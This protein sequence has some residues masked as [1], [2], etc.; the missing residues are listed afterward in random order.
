MRTRPSLNLLVAIAT[1]GCGSDN[2]K[3]SVST[4]KDNVCSQVAAVACYDLY[5]CCSEGQIEQFL[6]V[7]D[8]RTEDQCRDDVQKLC[9]QQIGIVSSSIAA[10]RAKFDPAV[11]NA[12]LKAFLPKGSECATVGD[13]LPWTMACMMS[14]WQGTVADGGMCFFAFE[15]ASTD[16]YCAANQTCVALPV[17]GQPC[18]PQGCASTAF[19]QNGTC[20]AR[21]AQGGMCNQTRDCQASLYCDQGTN[22]CQPLLPGGATC[23]GNASCVSG[24]CNP[25]LCNGTNNPCFDNTQCGGMC[26]AG[27]NVGNFCQR[28]SQCGGG[29]CSVTTTMQ[30][31]AGGGCPPAETCVF[32]YPCSVG[33]C[34]GDV[35]CSA[36]EVAIDYCTAPSSIPT[37]PPN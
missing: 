14:A 19:C 32:P 15:C 33:T 27:P 9:E 3:P 11:M 7:G 2:S 6:H 35:V 21:V 18:A 12:C 22:M 8:P 37:P 10:G 5:Q 25:G 29:H 24:Q 13:A 26:S 17:D 23:N 31:G 1:I 28:D 30:C 36:T 4:T 20:R 16:S 34:V